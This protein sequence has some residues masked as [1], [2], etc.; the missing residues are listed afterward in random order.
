MASVRCALL[1]CVTVF[2]FCVVAGCSVA[3]GFRIL[4]EPPFTK[5]EPQHWTTGL[6]YADAR[7]WHKWETVEIPFAVSNV[8][9][10]QFKIMTR[11]AYGVEQVQMDRSSDTIRML[12]QNIRFQIMKEDRTVVFEGRD[13][14]LSFED[15]QQDNTWYWSNLR[16][17]SGFILDDTA[18]NRRDA[19]VLYIGRNM[20]MRIRLL[21]KKK[22]I[23]R[24]SRR[25]GTALPG[26]W[27]DNIGVQVESFRSM[28][29]LAPVIY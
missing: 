7:P 29:Q 23:V 14:D 10:A 2:W 26:S 27:G 25:P 18:A 15:M 24:I 3:P 16:V 17:S 6:A 11:T 28:M 4:A 22:Y 19:S 21:P 5:V 1:S 9:D 20:E 8:I 13:D 12:N